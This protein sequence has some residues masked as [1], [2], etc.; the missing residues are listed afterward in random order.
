M[1]TTSSSSSLLSLVDSIP[2]I[3]MDPLKYVFETLALSQTPDGALWLEFGVWSGRTINYIAQYASGRVYGFDSFEG[4]PE[5]WRPGF[6]KGEFNRGGALPAVR[7]N[8]Q[9]VKGWFSDTLPGF[10]RERPGQ[11]VA[12]LHLDAD[13]YSSTIFVLEA[14]K[15]RL[16]GCVVVFDELVNYDGFDGATG[17]LRAWHEF[18]SKHEVDYKWIGMNGRVGAGGEQAALRIRSV[19]IIA[20]KEDVQQQSK[21]NNV[22]FAVFAGR[23]R[24]LSI[25]VRYLDRLIAAASITEVHLWDFTRTKDDAAYLRELCSNSSSSRYRLM[26]PNGRH[27]GATPDST[28][29]DAYQYYLEESFPPDSVLVKCDDDVVHLSGGVAGFDAFIATVMRHDGAPS[30]HALFFPNIVNNDACARA[31]NTMRALGGSSVEHYYNLLAPLEPIDYDARTARGVGEPMTDWYKRT[32]RATAAH[33]YFLANRASYDD[34]AVETLSWDS[35]FSI[36]MFAAKMSTAQMAFTLMKTVGGFSSDERFLSADLCRLLDRPNLIVP[37]LTVVHFAYSYQ[38]GAALDAEFLHRY[39]ALSCDRK[40][41]KDCSTELR[42]PVV[43]PALRAHLEN[44]AANPNGMPLAHR[45]FLHKLRNEFGFEPEVAYDLGS[46]VGHWTKAAREVWP[47]AQYVLFD[48]Y[49][50][51]EFLYVRAKE[52]YHIGVLSDADDRVVRFYQNDNGPN[53]NSYFR[54]VGCPYGDFFPADQYVERTCRTLDSVV[55]E[56]GFPAPDL[57]KIDV[58]GCEMDIIKGALATLRSAQYL[59]VEL[60]D[61]NYNDGAPKADVTLPFIESLGWTCIARKFSDN[62]PDADYCFRRNDVNALP[63]PPPSPQQQPQLAVPQ[64]LFRELRTLHPQVTGYLDLV[65]V[66]NK[67]E[68]AAATIELVGWAFQLGAPAFACQVRFRSATPPGIALYLQA[69]RRDDVVAAHYNQ[70]KQPLPLLPAIAWCG[71]NQTLRGQQ[72]VGG[73]TLEME[74]LNADDDWEWVAFMKVAAAV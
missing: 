42:P 48:G 64:P 52:M 19:R 68:A 57:I 40:E 43:P 13:L 44:M 14:L 69:V 3:K 56:R 73:G 1:T 60:Q 54:E 9:L 72:W 22:Y 4:L 23:R 58:Q 34:C 27:S 7:S 31:Q 36:N 11:Q 30:K 32:D 24:Y 15:D 67:E 17:E 41:E 37:S 10:L 18:V 12:F 25:L 26:K 8:V 62:G 39:D 49:A 59:I 66:V 45:E 38:D 53:G 47:R 71:W 65:R 6:E 5:T 55:A 74:I 63:V 20:E 33:R 29:A 28:W 51:Y 21:S 16:D 35:R 70:Q 50:P 61:T 46:C 2:D